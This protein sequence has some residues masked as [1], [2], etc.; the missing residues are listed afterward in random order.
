MWHGHLEFEHLVFIELQLLRFRNAVSVKAHCEL[1]LF[2]SSFCLF[3]SF[4]LSRRCL[5]IN[6]S[7][8]IRSAL[9]VAVQRAGEN[10]MKAIH[11]LLNTIVCV[12]VCR[13]LLHLKWRW[14]K[15]NKDKT[16]EQSL[17][18]WLLKPSHLSHSLS[19][20]QTLTHWQPLTRG[21]H[22]RGQK[23]IRRNGFIIC[24]SE[25]ENISHE[26]CHP[27]LIYMCCISFRSRWKWQLC[28][29][30]T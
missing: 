10:Q 12:C 13:R 18:R 2:L 14:L 17:S 26:S 24:V 6:L 20:T 19:P 1:I 16:L 3:S 21:S 23:S 11:F 27:C 22:W 8:L 5:C 25:S 28:V 7:R 4:C 9:T 29:S 15:L 30:G